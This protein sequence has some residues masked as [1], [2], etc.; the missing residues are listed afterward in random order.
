[1]FTFPGIG[2]LGLL[3]FSS[4]SARFCTCLS[5]NDNWT[6]SLGQCHNKWEEDREHGVREALEL[7]SEVTD[8]PAPKG[9]FGDAVHK[10]GRTNGLSI[11]RSGSVSKYIIILLCDFEPVV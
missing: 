3:A 10:T 4:V 5:W 9:I 11:Q 6:L 7:Y 1:M 2:L 8:D